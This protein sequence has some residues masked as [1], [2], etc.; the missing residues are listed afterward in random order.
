MCASVE[1]YG[2]GRLLSHG[3]RDVVERT[4]T[5]IVQLV[6]DAN[7]DCRCVCV[8]VMCVGVSKCVCVCVYVCVSE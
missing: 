4:L 7:P 5:A 2:P 8:C 1:R 6:G 3:S